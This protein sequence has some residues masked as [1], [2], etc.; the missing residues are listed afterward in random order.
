VITVN[1]RRNT[2]QPVLFYFSPPSGYGPSLLKMP[3]LNAEMNAYCRL[4]TYVIR[5]SLFLCYIH[6]SIRPMLP[7]VKGT[8]QN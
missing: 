6:M 3:C 1:I 2:T 4:G 7:F 5:R 8:K